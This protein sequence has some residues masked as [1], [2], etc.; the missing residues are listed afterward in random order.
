M[1]KDLSGAS[2]WWS[3]TVTNEGYTQGLTPNP[4]LL[5]EASSNKH[6]KQSVW[7]HANQLQGSPLGLTFFLM[8]T[9]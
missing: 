8:A 2:S 4:R 9:P 5:S 7:R 6:D 3:Q 1:F